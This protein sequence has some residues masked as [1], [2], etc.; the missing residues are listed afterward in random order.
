MFNGLP[1]ALNRYNNSKDQWL[2]LA[3]TKYVNNAKDPG[4]QVTKWSVKE[5][6]SKQAVAQTAAH[7][8][9]SA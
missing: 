4:S 6:T 1:Y 8:N 2:T 5:F 3:L 7:R 9:I